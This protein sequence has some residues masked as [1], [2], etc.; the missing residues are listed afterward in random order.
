MFGNFFKF[1]KKNYDKITE[2]INELE[3]EEIL[4][5][6]F[7]ELHKN[8][9]TNLYKD[10]EIFE[11]REGYKNNSIY[12]KINNTVTIFGD[13][14]LKKQLYSIKS[15]KNELLKIQQIVN[16]LEKD[17]SKFMK[18]NNIL[19]DLKK[20]E[21]DI[22]WLWKKQNQESSNYVD[23]VFFKGFLLDKL[24]ES[25]FFLKIYNFYQVI[26]SPLL[27]IL[28]PVVCIIVP[29]LLVKFLTPR[30]IEFTDYFKILNFSF[31]GGHF[32]NDERALKYAQYFSVFL[33]FLY[34]VHTVYSNIKVSSGIN[35]IINL[36]HNKINNISN[37]IKKSFE[38]NCD[39]FDCFNCVKLERVCNNLWAQVFN[40]IPGLF[41]DKGKI[42]IT[43]RQILDNR[44]SLIPILNFI[45]SV[46]SFMS[47]VKL[48][49]IQKKFENQYSFPV[50]IPSNTPVFICEK[51]WHPFLE[52]SKIITNNIT[53]GGKERNNA[54]IT[55]PNAGG[56]S[57]F[58]KSL[59][60]SILLAQ[61]L[62]ISCC[63]KLSFSLF[64]NLE[65]Y[66]NIPDIKGKESLFEA[67]VNRSL[68]YIT[69]LSKF[70]TNEFSLIVMDEIFNSTNPEE[71]V[72]GG[73]S[74]CKKLSS[75]HNN[76]SVI[77]THFSFL[78]MLEKN[79]NSFTNYK[80]PVERDCNNEIIY[81]YKILKG[82]SKQY[83]AIEL[84]RNKG[85]DEEI[86]QEALK[87]CKQIQKKELNKNIKLTK[88]KN[89]NS[90][91]IK[92]LKDNINKDQKQIL[93]H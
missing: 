76:I 55:G 60:I 23:Q 12:S 62:G 17:E 89:Y 75:Y 25:E 92:K 6:L 65:T 67:E 18:I 41:T 9:K 44:N 36:I 81:P 80:I 64:S 77:T 56:K 24:N 34:Y 83:I 90:K 26:I 88:N 43:Y 19:S 85:F 71:G 48:Y 11:D 45:G 35:K 30:D 46:D 61:T 54:L 14:N 13:Y 84:L 21:M 37:F 38:I 69:D 33:W 59:V 93:L 15:N 40:K 74:I 39:Y 66:L 72:S 78:S 52:N 51:L 58:I 5:S 27:N 63:N 8:T 42:L 16:D 7:G 87:I 68:E 50:Y 10:L 57:T 86:I 73:Y 3:K 1:Q 2:N 20:N 47:I 31:K 29:Y 82:I 28:T 22:L 70:N 49:K 91:K 53:L 79:T 4:I 32:M